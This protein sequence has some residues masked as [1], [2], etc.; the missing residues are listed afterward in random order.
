MCNNTEAPAW[1]LSPYDI[2]ILF[3]CDHIVEP[4]PDTIST[5]SA[6]AMFLANELIV[7]D[8]GSESGYR[9][10]VRGKCLVKMLCNTPLP[11]YID[12]RELPPLQR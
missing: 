9:T 6:V 12:P 3:H 2:R 5:R 8:P 4:L 11:V 7:A 10:T 1:H